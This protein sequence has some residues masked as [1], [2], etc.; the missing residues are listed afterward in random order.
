MKPYTR[1]IPTVIIGPT[2]IACPKG[3]KDKKTLIRVNIP[4]NSLH[5]TI[6]S[7]SWI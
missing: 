6:H 7:P 5:Q 2:Y 1:V 4:F 3:R